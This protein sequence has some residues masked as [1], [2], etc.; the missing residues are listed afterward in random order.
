MIERIIVGSCL[1]LLLNI[2]LSLL[3]N[4]S[5]FLLL[6]LFAFIIRPY[7]NMKHNIFFC[8]S[9]LVCM[10]IQGIYLAYKMGLTN[11]NSK[12]NI[13]IILPLVVCIL[14]LLFVIYGFVFLVISLI[15]SNREHKSV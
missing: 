15:R 4:I 1:V 5:I 13:W 12:A 14:L 9:M 3:L 6:F 11:E 8:V 10:I 2:Q 7:M